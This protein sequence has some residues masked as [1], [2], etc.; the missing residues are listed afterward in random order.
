ME[1]RAGECDATAVAQRKGAAAV[2]AVAAKTTSRAL[3]DWVER[4]HIDALA[5]LFI[6]LWLSITVINW[7]MDFADE[8]YE[9]AG[10]NI[11]GII[12]AVLTPWGLMQAAMFK[13]YVDLK[14]KNGKESA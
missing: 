13:F 11:A 2:A 5:V 7:A 3:W 14:S 12:A 1:V 6:T 10:M 4:H 9:V 8:H